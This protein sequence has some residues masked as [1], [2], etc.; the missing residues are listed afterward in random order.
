M[1]LVTADRRR[2]SALVAGVAT[3]ALLVGCAPGMP[4]TVLSGTSVSIGWHEQLT[5][6]NASSAAGATVGNLDVA[7]LTRGSFMQQT[8][9][10]LAQN[11]SFGTVR[12]LDQDPF[13]VRYDLADVQWSDSVP[14]DSTDLL[15][16][17]AAGSNALAPG[18]L[19][20]ATLVDDD[21]DVH[22]PADV[23]WFDSV[24]TGLAQSTELPTVDEQSRSITITYDTSVVDWRTALQVSVPAHVLGQIA[25]GID[26]PMVAKR[27]V[28]DALL[29]GSAAELAELAAAWNSGFT[30]E[31]GSDPSLLVS[32]GPYVIESTS[33]SGVDLTVNTRYEAEL[34]T[35]YEDLSLVRIQDGED[36]AEVQQGV[37]V[38]Q[39]SPGEASYDD[40]LD[41]ELAGY[42]RQASNDGTLWS[43]TLRVDRGVFESEAARWSFLHAA[44]PGEMVSRAG[45]DWGYESTSFLLIPPGAPA[46]EL[47][48]EESGFDQAYADAEPLEERIAAGVPAGTDVCVLY[49]TDSAFATG[50]F[51][52]LEEGVAESGWDVQDCGASDLEAAQAESDWDA[53]IANVPVPTTPQAIAAQWGTGGAESL[54]GNFDPERDAL[55][56]AYA[57]S[58]TYVPADDTRTDPDAASMDALVAIESSIIEDAVSLPLAMQPVVTIAQPGVEGIGPI[59][60]PA[61]QLTSDIVNWAPEGSS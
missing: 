54:S 51:E 20:P 28:A 47:A 42:G 13:E 41:L 43:L 18:D 31:G 23:P 53:I 4:E 36:L 6:M 58:G 46:Q 33:E 19:D 16:A 24:T 45:G 26:D 12:V 39:V 44:P 22:V 21:G 11:P 10:G 34:T 7:A 29:H 48:T 52:A 8:S 40:V 14:I 32:S 25:F 50:A 57:S 37:D 3:L 1:S 55:I 59:D 56:A 61:A 49:D 15:V 38:V 35:A 5:S 17:W 2:G 9:T 30:I 60:G 27:A